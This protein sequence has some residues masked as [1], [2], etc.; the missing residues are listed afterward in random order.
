MQA[1][2]ERLVMENNMH[3]E[4]LRQEFDA[5]ADRHLSD[6]KRYYEEKLSRLE[7]EKVEL[8]KIVSSQYEQI[9]ELV[10]KY[11]QT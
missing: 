11:K 5:V 4:E 7:E 8:K 6:F 2:E 1:E 3:T 9:T 10:K